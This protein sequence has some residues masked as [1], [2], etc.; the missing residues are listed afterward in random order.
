[1]MAQVKRMDMYETIEAGKAEHVDWGIT[2]ENIGPLGDRFYV[3]TFT[4]EGKSYEFRVPKALLDQCSDPHFTRSKL[5]EVWIE[6]LTGLTSPI[7]DAYRKE[8]P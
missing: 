4:F 7:F 6:G 5:M 3:E 2:V 1:M 8:K